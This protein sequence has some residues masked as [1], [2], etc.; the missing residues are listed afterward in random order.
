VW[1]NYQKAVIALAAL[2][3]LLFWASVR[4]FGPVL[5]DPA[6]ARRSLMEHINASG[7]WLWKAK[8]GRQVLID[9][10]RA[11]LQATLQRRAPALLRLSETQQHDE[12]ALISGLA[13][14][15]IAH[16][17]H[18]EPASVDAEFTRQIHTL[19]TLRKHYER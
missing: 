1:K 9:A 11:D 16:A 6:P 13:P 7:A 18:Y 2:L 12:L 3:A 8:G 14:A 17:M 10:A 19:Q 15:V 4:R 5:P